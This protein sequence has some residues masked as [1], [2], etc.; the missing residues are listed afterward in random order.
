VT[1]RGRIVG[2]GSAAALIVAGGLLAALTSGTL[3]QVL[4]LV[5]L[6]LGLVLVTSLVFFEVGLSEDREREE[7]E[8]EASERAAREGSQRRRPRR[9]R[10]RLPRTRGQRRRLG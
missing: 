3:G 10:P 5:A 7:R 4:G 8:R 6:G 9:P 1:G 2:Y